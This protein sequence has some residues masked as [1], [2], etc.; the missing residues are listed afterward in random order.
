MEQGRNPRMENSDNNVVG[1][2]SVKLANY[3]NSVRFDSGVMA[4]LRRGTT[5]DGRMGAERCLSR[6]GV[7]GWGESLRE[8]HLG[9]AMVVGVVFTI[10][11]KHDSQLGNFGDSMAVFLS[12]NKN[13]RTGIDRVAGLLFQSERGMMEDR[14]I[15]CAR[16]M[17]GYV[18]A[19]NM[20]RLYRDIVYWNSDVGLRW[21]CSYERRVAQSRERS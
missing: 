14:V 19:I 12:R 21:F 2:E 20:E 9:C 6:A 11:K 13:G 17:R 18:G 10:I 5:E 1:T 8:H 4:R 15:Q 7:V 3:L 16:R